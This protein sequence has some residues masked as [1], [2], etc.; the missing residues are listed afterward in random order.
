VESFPK[1]TLRIVLQI[2][3]DTGESILIGEITDFEQNIWNYIKNL[4]DFTLESLVKY[5]NK[6]MN[7]ILKSLLIFEQNL[8]IYFEEDQQQYINCYNKKTTR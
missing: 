5:F 3:T 1:Q 6:P 2:I 8:L 4:E 7:T